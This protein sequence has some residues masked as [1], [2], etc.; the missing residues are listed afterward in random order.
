MSTSADRSESSQRRGRPTSAE[1]Q[2]EVARLAEAAAGDWC[3]GGGWQFPYDFGDGVVAPTYAPAQAM[4]AWR[5][6]VMLRAV[7]ERVPSGRETLSVLDLGAGEGAM[8]IGLWQLGFRDI[9][10]VE[11]RALNVEK[12][13][14]AARVFGAELKFETGTIDQFLAANRRDYD[15]VL[16]MGLLYHVL[17]PFDLFA[18]LGKIARRFVVL[19]TALAVPRLQGFDNRPDYAP[20]EAGFFVRVDSAQSHTAG[21]TDIELWPNRAALEV[22]AQHGGFR[23]IAWLPGEDPV[24][25]DFAN[26]TRVLALMEK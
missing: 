12:A 7:A 13:R 26:N 24:P 1:I 11:V 4:H 17:N 16:C 6:D 3:P 23:R 21:L 15:V 19:E 8:A 22:L 14:F 20:R 25:P 10:C 9:V 18:G 2:R 5:R